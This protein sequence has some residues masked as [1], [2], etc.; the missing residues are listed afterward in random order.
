MPGSQL[1]PCPWRSQAQTATFVLCCFI[2]LLL[3]WNLFILLS[4][5][6]KPSTCFLYIYS[7]FFKLLQLFLKKATLVSPLTCFLNQYSH[8]RKN[9]TIFTSSMLRQS[10]TF[11]QEVSQPQTTTWFCSIPSQVCSSQ[12]TPGF[13]FKFL[14][15][16]KLEIDAT[17]LTYSPQH[18]LH[19]C[20]F[21]LIVIRSS[22][23][24][25]FAFWFWQ[26]QPT[27]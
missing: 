9:F 18:P 10:L 20:Q 1:S 6:Y 24:I 27:S 26:A 12:S 25:L 11:L 7:A 17:F 19:I 14:D 16:S 2:F 4:N 3:S 23:M 15:I 21:N 8:F 5:T 13:G 22:S